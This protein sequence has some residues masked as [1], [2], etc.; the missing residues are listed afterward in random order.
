MRLDEKHIFNQKTLKV[1]VESNSFVVD[2]GRVKPLRRQGRQ[3]NRSGKLNQEVKRMTS[4]NQSGELRNRGG[5]NDGAKS[6][7]ALFSIRLKH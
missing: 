3:W 4:V 6:V 7:L 2:G 1:L 5:K